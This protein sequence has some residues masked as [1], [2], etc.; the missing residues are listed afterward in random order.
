MGIDCLHVQEKMA[1]DLL[2]QQTKLAAE[3][4]VALQKEI[5]SMKKIRERESEL[6]KTEQVLTL[7]KY[8]IY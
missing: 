6:I 4:Q 7:H 1:A 8:I 5:Q 3:A 2:E